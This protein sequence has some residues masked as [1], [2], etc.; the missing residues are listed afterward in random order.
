MFKKI[1]IGG[2]VLAGVLA[3]AIASYNYSPRKAKA[4]LD[5]ANRIV[6]NGNDVANAAKNVNGLTFKS[7]GV[8]SCNSTSNL[9][10]DYKHQS[11]IAYN[12]LLNVLFGGEHP[13]MTHVKIEMGNDGNNSTGADS[14][15]M[16]FENEEADASRSPGWLLAA[17]AK[18]VNPD[19]KV[20][21][22][23]WE[24]PKW[25]QDKWD[26]NRTGQGFE[27]MYK[28]YKETIFDAYEKYGFIP[29][30][31][32]PD[33]NETWDP[34]NEFI[35]W[36]RNRVKNEDDFPDYFT[37]EAMD[38]YNNMKIIASDENVSL[39]I[40]PEMRSN[41]AL[42]NAVDAI[43]FHYSTGTSD[44]TSD[45]VR[46]AEQ[47][48]KE[49]WYSEGCGSFSYTEYHENKNESYGGGTLGGYQSPLALCDCLVKSA[50]YSRKSHYIFQPA[51]G[52]FYEGSQYDHKELLSAREPWS[53]NVHYDQVIYLLW[54]FCKFAKTGW[55]NEDN[56]AGVW[57]MIANAS[58]NNSDGTEHLRNENGRPSYL[59][60][61]S[62]DKKDFSTIIVNN[63]NK[64]L[65]YGISYPNMDIED[66]HLFEVWESR[67][68]SY[69]QCI[70]EVEPEDGV[71]YVSVEPFS[72]VTVTS[73]DCD[74]KEEYNTRLPDERTKYVLDTN[75]SGSALSYEGDIL[76]SDDF[77]YE[78]YDD[79][80]LES[81]GNEP[82][83]MVDMSGAFFVEDGRLVQK[84]SRAVSQ[85]HN[86]DPNT[87][88]GDHRWMNY[89]ASVDVY[90]GSGSY[91]GI[92]VRE[93]T[94]MSYTGSGY[95]LQV[96][97]S[98][99]WTLMKK[100]S[101]LSQG[102]VA[103]AS[104]YELS[105]EASGNKITA[106]IDGKQVATYT[107]SKP[108]YFGR[109]RLFCGWSQT[110]FDNLKVEKLE[111]DG[112]MNTVP[113]AVSLVDNLA[114]GVYYSGS[115]TS[116][117]GG[118]SADNWYRSTSETSSAGASFEFDFTGNGIALLGNNSSDASITL[119]VDDERVDTKNI[120][121]EGTGHG[122][123]YVYHGLD[124][125]DHT[126]K[127]TL[128][129]GR[130]TLDAILIFSE[131][132]PEIVVEKEPEPT[133]DP[134]S[135]IATPAPQ[136]NDQGTNTG[137]TPVP[138]NKQAVTSI[139]TSDGSDKVTS[140]KKPVIKVKINKKKKTA[141][142]TFAKVS[143]AEGYVI[144]RAAGKAK[145]KAVKTLKSAKKTISFTN[146]K[147]KTKTKYRYR[148]KAF[149][150]VDGKKVYSKYSKVKSI[151]L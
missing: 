39:N 119:T 9:L 127:V 37:D 67:T 1:I 47:D 15:T 88:V 43:G 19:V 71:V 111:Q 114:D 65:N 12:R 61:A 148:V 10:N 80:Y 98:G 54:H 87:V 20:S 89:K 49:V 130:F 146:K 42:Y 76:Y 18:K 150:T 112:T 8:L 90:P 139:T 41:N 63:S 13:L 103:S 85:W 64:T 125:D 38:L 6:V 79:D 137:I 24:M 144:E 28:W 151:K 105:V 68:D 4:A 2:L 11:P 32:N 30:Y 75:E 17:D 84:L 95:S 96:N 92:V 78:D 45:Y 100:G 149:A 136:N 23:R 72:I 48:D 121:N 25:V 124:E 143:G 5:N 132:P 3:V 122:S 145:F 50:V 99:H 70:D 116:K 133:E 93:Q 123:C 56:S 135:D 110:Y 74:E 108:A 59:T 36:Y 33:K 14:C 91:A 126:A 117:I 82:R 51:I 134:G 142:I 129:S 46:M 140:L 120:I 138:D 62:P 34:D 118:G 115:W 81:R 104:K 22:L 52:S 53:G 40:V 106:F 21:V 102:D 27:A 26:S 131:E 69:F 113:Y 60:L 107:D 29:D 66:D 57:R 44:S 141:K 128:N 101:N 7:F 94:G 35:V 109:I 83:Y 16:R 97:S 73:L 31:I 86:N 77:E 147:L 55:E 58:A